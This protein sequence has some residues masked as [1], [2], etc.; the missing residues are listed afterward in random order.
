MAVSVRSK[1][2]IAFIISGEWRESHRW[3]YS[4]HSRLPPR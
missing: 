4:T 1:L 3:K 2:L